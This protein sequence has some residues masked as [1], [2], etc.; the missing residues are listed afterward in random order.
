MTTVSMADRPPVPAGL[1]HLA[2][3]LDKLTDDEIGWLLAYM[4]GPKRARPLWRARNWWRRDAR[5]WLSE[6]WTG[7]VWLVT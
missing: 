6:F 1:E 5:R 4:T 3:W 7:L 2:R